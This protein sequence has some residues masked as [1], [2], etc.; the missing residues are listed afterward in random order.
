MGDS[1]Y[2]VE[3]KYAL[4][5]CSGARY[6]FAIP[7]TTCKKIS[8]FFLYAEDECRVPTFSP[9][10]RLLIFLVEAQDPMICKADLGCIAVVYDRWGNQL[11]LRND[12]CDE[13]VY[14]VIAN[15]G[16]WEHPH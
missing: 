3:G 5:A 7:R 8:S 15:N 11:E 10:N 9:E 4:Q 16:T 12:I 14:V 6:S 13:N 2:D 1:P